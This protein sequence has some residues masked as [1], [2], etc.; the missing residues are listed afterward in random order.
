MLKTLIGKTLT[1]IEWNEGEVTFFWDGGKARFEACGDCCSHT[2]IDSFEGNEDIIGDEIVK[3]TEL[4]LGGMD[5]PSA[6]ECK[7]KNADH[8]ADHKYGHDSLALYGY[9][10]ETNK[11]SATLDFRNDSNG[12]YGGSL[13]L[14]G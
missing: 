11:A 3:V 2:W 14:R 10:I 7:C 12:Y 5:N 9:R 13:E 8:D 1:K 4:E 6:E